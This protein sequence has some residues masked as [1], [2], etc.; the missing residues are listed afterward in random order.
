M[1]VPFW[2]EDTSGEL[3]DKPVTDI[4]ADEPEAAA[5][6]RAARLRAIGC[7]PLAEGREDSAGSFLILGTE[8]GPNRIFSSLRKSSGK[9]ARAFLYPAPDS[10]EAL[11][12][13]ALP[14]GPSKNSSTALSARVWL[15]HKSTNGSRVVGDGGFGPYS[16]QLFNSSDD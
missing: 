15:S 13:V 2:L 8:H 16:L 12:A 14:L 1:P 9:V 11:D 6:W 7:K 3:S 10:F 4:A 5:A